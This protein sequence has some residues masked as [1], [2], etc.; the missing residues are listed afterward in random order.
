M[1]LE[2]H[3]AIRA[4]ALAGALGKPGLVEAGHIA[5]EKAAEAAARGQDVE[6]AAFEDERVVDDAAIAGFDYGGA[7]PPIGRRGNR[8]WDVLVFDDAARGKILLRDRQ[9]QVG[10]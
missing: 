7:K 3:L 2:G 1:H 6:Q 10:L 5:G 8:Y 9:D 4:D